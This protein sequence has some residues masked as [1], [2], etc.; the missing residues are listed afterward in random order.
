[1]NIEQVKMI[2]IKFEQIT[3]KT[4]SLSSIHKHSRTYYAISNH[5]LRILL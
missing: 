1:M 5:K 2:D 4:S 3:V